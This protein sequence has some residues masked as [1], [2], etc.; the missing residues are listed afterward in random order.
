MKTQRLLI[1]IT[2][3]NML[4]LLTALARVTTAAT[5]QSTQILRG[6]GLEIEDARGRV[7]A[8]IILQPPSTLNGVRYPETILFRLIDPNGR[9]GVKIGTSPEGSGISLAGDSERRDWSGVQILADSAGSIVRLANRNGRQQV[10]K[11]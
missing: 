10:I 11:P 5:P 7:R 8:Q 1:V 6:R 9:P 2:A 4:I 3:L